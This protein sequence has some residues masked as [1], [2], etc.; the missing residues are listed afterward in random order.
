M[1]NASFGFFFGVVCSTLPH[2]FTRITLNLK[3]NVWIFATFRKL[4]KLKCILLEGEYGKLCKQIFV[5]N[6][7]LSKKKE[8]YTRH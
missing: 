8:E 2:F 5:V 7:S 3:F 1:V 6:E 4:H